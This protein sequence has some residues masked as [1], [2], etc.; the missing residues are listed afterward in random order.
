MIKFYDYPVYCTCAQR[1]SIIKTKFVH[2]EV[3]ILLLDE[4]TNFSFIKNRYLL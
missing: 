4:I 2:V 1:L 3:S